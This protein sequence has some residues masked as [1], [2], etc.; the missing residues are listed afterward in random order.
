MFAGSAQHIAQV[1]KPALA[2]GHWVVS[3]RFVD[4]SFAYQGGGRGF[5][6]EKI[7]LL[8]DWI[9][10][11]LKPDKTILL[12]APPELGLAR[13]KHRGPQDRI[14]QEKKDFFERVRAAYLSRAK[15]EP[16]R[17]EIIDATQLLEAVHA[18]IKKVLD[19]LILGK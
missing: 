7:N 2:A 8:A 6:M 1:I 19:N 9:V 18:D 3:D 4:A 16:T 17:F 10:G 12:D 15:E 14:E 5:D 13:A 11:E